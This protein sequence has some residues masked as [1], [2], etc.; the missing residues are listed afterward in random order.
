ME[1]EDGGK[2]RVDKVMG[3]LVCPGGGQDG[4]QTSL[5]PRWPKITKTLLL[6][7]FTC[8]QAKDLVNAFGAGCSEICA[9]HLVEAFFLKNQPGTM[10]RGSMELM[11]MNSS[12]QRLFYFLH[13]KDFTIKSLQKGG[14]AGY[15]HHYITISPMLPINRFISMLSNHRTAEASRQTGK[16]LF[17]LVREAG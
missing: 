6:F 12:Q 2:E 11:V 15:A 14:A 16:K 13:F 9:R 5:E 10:E 8:V 1:R 7:A 3:T 17:V 4:Y